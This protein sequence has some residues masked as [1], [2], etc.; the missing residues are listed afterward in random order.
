MSVRAYSTSAEQQG[1][2]DERRGGEQD[3]TGQGRQHLALCSAQPRAKMDSPSPR[4][5][6]LTG[7]FDDP[8]ED[9][10]SSLGGGDSLFP[11][12]SSVLEL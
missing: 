12:G 6:L 5:P 3:R 1:G 9:R 8:S 2:G 4:L 11:L 10:A 7:L